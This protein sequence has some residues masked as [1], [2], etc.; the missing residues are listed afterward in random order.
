[1]LTIAVLI[2][3]IAVLAGGLYYLTR[4]KGDRES[5]K[6]YGVTAIVGAAAIVGAVIKIIVSGV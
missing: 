4:S 6:I 5:Q 1:M 3:G 2:I